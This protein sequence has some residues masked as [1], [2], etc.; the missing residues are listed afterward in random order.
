[1]P[2]LTDDERAI[3]DLMAGIN[4]NSGSIEHWISLLGRA[5][6]LGQELQART[7]ATK[8]RKEIGRELAAMS[9]RP[10]ASADGR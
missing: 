7:I 6:E 2:A 5:A 9:Q 8:R 1:M 4:A 3:L 10:S